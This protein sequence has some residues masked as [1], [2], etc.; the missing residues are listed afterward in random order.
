MTRPSPK[1]RPKDSTK[2]H[3]TKRAVTTAAGTI[4][5]R[6]AEREGGRPAE[7][8]PARS[9]RPAAPADRELPAAIV[10]VGA[11]A[12]GLEAFS[13]VLEHLGEAPDVAVIFVQHLSPQH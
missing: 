3:A 9:A 8:V 10:A 12:G 4:T 11:S 6:R 13:Q 2:K 1:S 5:H 7:P